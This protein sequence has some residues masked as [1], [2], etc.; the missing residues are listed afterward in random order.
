VTQQD[1]DSIR[2]IPNVIFPLFVAPNE[3]RLIRRAPAWRIRRGCTELLPQHV[4]TSLWGLY[5]KGRSAS[6]ANAGG[7]G[8]RKG[9]RRVSRPLRGLETGRNETYVPP[10]RGLIPPSTRTSPLRVLRYPLWSLLQQPGKTPRDH[11]E[12]SMGTATGAPRWVAGRTRQGSGS[13]MSGLAPQCGHWVRSIPVTSCI[14]C[15]TLGG[16]RGEGVAGWPKSSR[17]RPSFRAL[18]RLA[19]KP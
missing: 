4:R 3:A 16:W 19:R 1:G 14:H 6:A 13:R 8:R 5:H 15:T 7:C 18:C 10:V 2:M 11:D 17:Q 9:E 12:S